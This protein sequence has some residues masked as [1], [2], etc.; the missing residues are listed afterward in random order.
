[1]TIT[2]TSTSPGAAVHSTGRTVRAS[3][4]PLVNQTAISLSRYMRPSVSTT[5]TNR[6]KVIIVGRCAMAAKPSS[7]TTSW[8]EAVPRAACPR[9]R[10]SIIVST[11]VSTTT[12][13]A[14]KLRPSS[15]LS[16][17]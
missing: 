7:S 5:A 9:V 6:D 2:P 12:K 10:M 13:V 15:F 3:D 4:R 11:M 16:A 8:G 14:A 17:P 1:M